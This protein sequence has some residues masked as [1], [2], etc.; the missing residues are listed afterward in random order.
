[1]SGSWVRLELADPLAIGAEFVRWEVATA[2]AGM[3]L[4]ID[5]FDQPN[6]QE[7]KDATKALLEAFRARGTLP[8][9]AP[10]VSEPG[11]SAYADAAALGDDPVSVEGT[12]RALFG[13]AEAGDYLAMLA[14]LP[15]DPETEAALQGLRAS[16]GE[17]LGI[18]T[19]L[20]FGP[21]FLH[22]TG[23]LHKGGPASGIFL[24]L[25][26]EPRRDMPI[27]GWQETF[28]TLV[29]AQALGDLESLQRRGR[30]VVRLHFG[31]PDGV[32]ERL[33]ALIGAALPEVAR[34]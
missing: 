3:V 20:G 15:Q 22:S 13:T 8:S 21:R 5:P 4:G 26:A 10:L 30:R 23:Q 33:A 2:M 24:Q 32:A 9:P 19:T 16:I 7:S 34:A 1:M 25:T 27:P 12:L 28:G 18:A 17:A 6:V 29:A 11:V 14:Y 31:Q